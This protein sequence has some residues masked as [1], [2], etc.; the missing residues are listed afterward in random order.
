MENPLEI[1]LLKLASE[2][3]LRPWAEGTA[4][5]RRAQRVSAVFVSAREPS[6]W[7]SAPS[8]PSHLNS[9]LYLECTITSS[10]TLTRA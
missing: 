6:I 4:R 8:H 10:N 9:P 3:K 5:Q 7:K 1:K 2:I